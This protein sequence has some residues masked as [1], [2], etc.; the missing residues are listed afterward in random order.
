MGPIFIGRP[1]FQLGLS[2]GKIWP[3]SRPLIRGFVGCVGVVNTSILH[4]A[5]NTASLH[6][7]S[8]YGFTSGSQRYSKSKMETER[9]GTV[10]HNK[11]REG[12]R[13]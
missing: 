9:N 3:S 4:L 5:G 7:S 8:L 11:G 1:T 2:Q 12:K 13:E 10:E 6:S